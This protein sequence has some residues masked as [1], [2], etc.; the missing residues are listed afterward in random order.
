MAYKTGSPLDQ[1]VFTIA[2]RERS[3]IAERVR[4]GLRRARPSLSTA[5]GGRCRWTPAM[6]RA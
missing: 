2:Q 4:A 5:A 1:A 6:S 3:L